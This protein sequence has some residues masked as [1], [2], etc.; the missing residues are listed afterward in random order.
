MC[1]TIVCSAVMIVTNIGLWVMVQR[2]VGASAGRH[3]RVGAGLPL[4][5]MPPAGAQQQ[6]R[7]VKVSRTQMKALVT[8]TVVTS[9]FLATWIPTLT[10][11]FIASWPFKV[12][13][14]PAALDKVMAGT[15]SLGSWFNP[16]IYTIINKG[17]RD[18]MSGKI[19]R[20][21]TIFS[22]TSFVTE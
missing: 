20:R 3:F 1:T 14:P 4:Q 5:D 18:F 11:Y 8:T 13:V 15:F 16:I 19:K 2:A 22:G 21:M 6:S 17:F 10:R 12:V 9:F 7:A